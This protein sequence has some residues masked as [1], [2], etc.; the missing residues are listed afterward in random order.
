MTILGRRFFHLACLLGLATA[1]AGAGCGSVSP[2]GSTGGA[3]SGGDAAAETAPSVTTEQ[4]CS[5]EAKALCDAL[6]GCA[7]ILVK[8]AY[9]DK[10]VCIS[11]A[12]LSC[13]TDQSVPGITRTPGDLV[14]CAEA[15]A[16]ASCA[17]LEA[18]TYPTACAIKPGTV[19]NGAACGADGQ[20]ASTYCAKTDACGVCGPREAAGGDCKVDGGCQMGLACANKKCVAPAGPGGDCNLPNQPCRGDLYCS[21]TTSKCA[22]KVGVGGSCADSSDA[23]DPAKGAACI[24]K[25]CATVNVAKGGEACGAVP[26]AICVGGF[27]PCSNLLNG[28]CANPANDGE[29]C[30]AA[31]SGKKCIPPATC[32]MGL[33]RLPSATNCH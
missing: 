22:A 12:V 15:L 6:D 13:T 33:C 24:N 4:G 29:A 10:T 14:S 32:E 20:C 9:G 5:Q 23:C 18:G 21:P 28:I 27:E 11:R 19:I 30:G 8:L 26:K 31:A 7:A 2:A 25:L 1:A 3:G 17:D 16:T